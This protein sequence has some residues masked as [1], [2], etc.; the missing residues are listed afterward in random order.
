MIRTFP[1]DDWIVTPWTSD[2][3]CASWPMKRWMRLVHYLIFIGILN[4]G[5]NRLLLSAILTMQRIIRFNS[6]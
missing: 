2:D 3:V 6:V 1:L 5:F 4:G